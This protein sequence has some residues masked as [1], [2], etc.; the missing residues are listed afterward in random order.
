MKIISRPKEI[1][2][3]IILAKKKGKLIGFVPTMGAL[4]EGHLR[5]IRKA[6]KDCDI[7]VVSIFVNPNQFGPKEDLNR[8]PRP[9]QKDIA[10]CRKEKVD[11]IFHPSTNDMYPAGFAT[12]I[13]VEGMSGL[14]CGRSRPGHFRAVATVV[15]K[16][17]NIINPDIA[18]FGQKDAQQAIIVK[19][20][21]FDLNMPPEIRVLPTARDDHGL[22]FSSRNVYLSRQEKED[23]PVL[24]NSLN[25]AAMR[26]KSGLR[27]ARRITSRMRSLILKK[28]S[29]KIDYIAIVDTFTLEPMN[30]IYGECLIALAVWIGKTRIIDN[31][32][33]R[34][35]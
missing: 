35:R 17:F 5:L 33:V 24:F 34:G 8:Y 2:N 20:M 22:A 13:E 7:V 25:L 3:R 28:K 11:Y 6:R 32:I 1:R 16:L 29:A 30:K 19:K 10:L 15:A 9:I 23:A 21:A 12:H 27:D 31:M 26:I 4:H 14:L 18:Y